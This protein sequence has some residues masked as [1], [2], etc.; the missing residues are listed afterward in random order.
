M[1]DTRTSKFW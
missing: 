1:T